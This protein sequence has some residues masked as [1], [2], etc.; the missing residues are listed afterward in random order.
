M[1]SHFIHPPLSRYFIPSPKEGKK[2]S[3]VIIALDQQAQISEVFT[4]QVKGRSPFIL[5]SYANVS[6]SFSLRLS[7]TFVSINWLIKCIRGIKVEV[8]FEYTQRGC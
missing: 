7:F 1:H 2:E 4:S 3:T 8:C 5:Q 6:L